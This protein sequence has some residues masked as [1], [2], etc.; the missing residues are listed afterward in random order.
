MDAWVEFGKTVLD[1]LN[2][3]EKRLD[4]IETVL[5]IESIN[6][7]SDINTDDIHVSDF[8]AYDS[9]SLKNE[10][11]DLQAKLDDIKSLFA[12]KQ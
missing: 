6:E 11:K 3:I 2:R 10:L 7:D 1:K 5:G 9:E 8:Q 4:G 12:G